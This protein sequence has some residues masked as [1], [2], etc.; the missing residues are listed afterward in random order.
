[1]WT[2]EPG[3]LLLYGVIADLDATVVLPM[4]RAREIQ[5]ILSARTWGELRHG[6]DSTAFADVV[7]RRGD[8]EEDDSV[9]GDDTSFDPSPLF[10]WDDGDFPEW[11]QQRM[12]DWLP[13]DL[14]DRY[15]EVGDTAFSGEYVHID[16]G[17]VEDLAYDLVR[18]GFKCFRDDTLVSAVSRF[19]SVPEEPA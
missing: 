14:L 5:T 4:R 12:L 16:G 11:P 10:G 3:E 1:M 9:P 17:R 6:L 8:G 7:S 19:D 2:V 18:R 13:E 15:V